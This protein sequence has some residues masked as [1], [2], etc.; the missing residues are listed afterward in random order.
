MEMIEVAPGAIAFVRPKEG[1]NASLIRTREG[2]VVIDTTSC[3]AD[4]R[5]LLDAAGVSPGEVCLVI[6]T[7]QHSDHTWGNQVFSSPILAHRLCKEAMAAQLEGDWR[8]DT[9][10]ASIR[11][12]A[13]REPGWVAEMQ[14]KV[15]GLE[16]TLPTETFEVRRA[17]DIGGL[18]IDVI[19]MGGHSPGASVVWLPTE[20]V[21]FSG[22]LLF[23]E[24]Y[25]FIGD[26][27]IP[28]LLSALQRLL[29]FE[30]ETIVPGHG[31]LCGKAEIQG[32][33]DYIRGTWERTVDHLAQGHTADKAASDPGYPRYAE[34]AAERYHETN[35]R[36]MYERLTG[37]GSCLL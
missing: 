19:H 26:A 30:T 32:M 10:R 7:H 5:A 36:V 3:S 25:P 12:R 1:A 9:L 13:E 21:L 29:R 18:R 6:N 17:L 37:G 27:D 15:D 31:P 14:R 35:I 2:I 11:E 24:R 33:L 8:M 16:I 34:G 20:N 23:V 28:D 4:M 22:D